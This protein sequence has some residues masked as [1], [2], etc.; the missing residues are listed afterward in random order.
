MSAAPGLQARHPLPH[1][2]QGV[3]HGGCSPGRRSRLAHGEVQLVLL[4]P[5]PGHLLAPWS[6]VRHGP[7]ITALMKGCCQTICSVSCSC[8][9]QCVCPHHPG[10]QRRS[11]DSLVAGHL[12]VQTPGDPATSPRPSTTYSCESSRAPPGCPGTT[13]DNHT[14]KTAPVENILFSA[15][16]APKQLELV[17]ACSQ[18]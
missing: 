13:G 15:Q 6:V 17:T 16:S 4:L 14:K 8:R 12:A 9:V 18:P 1:Q 11:K 3:E 2:R 10:M 7:N 5:G